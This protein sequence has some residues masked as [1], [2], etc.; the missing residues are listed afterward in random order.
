MDSG[1]RDV[2]YVRMVPAPRLPAGG[3]EGDGVSDLPASP[4]AARL[5][6]PSW[7]DARLALGVLLVLVSVVV[8]ARVLSSADRSSSV[9]V[10]TRDLAVGTTLQPG[11]LVREQVRLEDRQVD[12]R[13]LEA[14]DD[15]AYVGFVTRRP[16]DAREFVPLAAL[17]RAG[18]VDERQ[19]ALNVEPGHAPPDLRGGEIVDVYVTPEQDRAAPAATPS[20]GARPDATPVGARL[21]LPG[22]TVESAQGADG[23]LGGGGEARPVVLNLAPP[24]VLQLVAAVAEGRI[25]LVRVRGRR[26]A[27][28]T[29]AASAAPTVEAG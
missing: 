15:D 21:V 8:G 28:A 27:L 16:L 7:L 19:F 5:A 22:V 23:G 1:A 2:R 12:R 6:S 26:G 10:A 9:L 14:D 13:L 11:D 18:D 3:R 24:Q 17:R 25:D 20:P 29:A 4:R